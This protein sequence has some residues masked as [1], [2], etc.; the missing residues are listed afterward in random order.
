MSDNTETP[1]GTLRAATNENALKHSWVTL[2]GTV[3]K[4]DSVKALVRYSNGKI[5]SVTTG[6]KL[7]SGTIVAIEDGTLMLALNGTSRKLVV[8]GG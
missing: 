1:Q 6:D 2:L 8:P 5:K 7:G 4:P 3:I